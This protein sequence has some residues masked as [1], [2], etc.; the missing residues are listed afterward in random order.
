MVIM[1]A[2]LENHFASP[3]KEAFGFVPNEKIIFFGTG[4]ARQRFI[5]SQQCLTEFEN[6]KLRRLENEIQLLQIN[7][8]EYHPK[9][10]RNDLLRFCYGTGWKTRVARDVLCK[11]LKWHRDIMPSGYMSLYPRVHHLFV[12]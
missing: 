3:P 4:K 5:F 6:E 2:S 10:T 1:E 8:F 12:R 7:P 11:Y 9:W